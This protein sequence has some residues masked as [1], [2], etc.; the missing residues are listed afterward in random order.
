MEKNHDAGVETG[1]V[2][3]PLTLENKHWLELL[4]ALSLA[5]SEHPK[6]YKGIRM[7]V[8]H[9]ARRFTIIPTLCDE[10]G[11]PVGSPSYIP[12]PFWD[13]SKPVRPGRD[14]V[15]V[16]MLSLRGR[17][18][19]TRLPLKDQQFRPEPDWIYEPEPRDGTFYPIKEGALGRVNQVL[20]C[21]FRMASSWMKPRGK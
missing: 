14:Y 4:Q 17:V 12:D 3:F 20:I 11:N 16:D 2:A 13:S 1:Q 15:P 7:L 21:G 6:L 9:A 10:H 5:Q 18:L 19:D 8:I